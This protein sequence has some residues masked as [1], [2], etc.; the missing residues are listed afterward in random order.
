M[1]RYDLTTSDD[2]EDTA[3]YDQRDK[4]LKGPT[5]P[6]NDSWYI[7]PKQPFLSYSRRVRGL[8]A[9]YLARNWVPFT[10][11]WMQKMLA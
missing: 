5:T 4:K 8:E 7:T 2:S 11:A 6:S 1:F 3:E 10:F 9:L